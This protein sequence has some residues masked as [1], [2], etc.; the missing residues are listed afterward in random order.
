MKKTDQSKVNSIIL[1][2]VTNLGLKKKKQNRM[3][4]S[5]TVLYL[6]SFNI[7]VYSK[8]YTVY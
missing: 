1:K 8:L 3:N 5:I 6:G 7:T 4:A 2:L